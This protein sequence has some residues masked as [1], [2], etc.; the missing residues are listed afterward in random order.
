MFRSRQWRMIRARE[1]QSLLEYA[2]ILF[3]VALA[4]VG[5]LGLFGAELLKLYN[6]IVARLPRA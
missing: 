1:G 2:L 3:L 5:G 6:F 4:A